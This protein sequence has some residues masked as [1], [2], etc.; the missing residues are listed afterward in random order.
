MKEKKH[1]FSYILVEIIGGCCRYLQR[2]GSFVS[3]QIFN[4]LGTLKMKWSILI[5]SKPI[6][7]H[8]SSFALSNHIKLDNLL[9]I[10]TKVSMWLWSKVSE[11]QNYKR[12]RNETEL[13]NYGWSRFA[14][15][16]LC[17][18]KHNYLVPAVGALL[19]EKNFGPLLH[20]LI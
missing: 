6:N 10:P 18:V 7:I 8:F 1:K 12:E 3:A 15:V 17:L 20:A 2:Y 9:S 13:V 5:A 14:L 4:V 11:E 19:E 16:L